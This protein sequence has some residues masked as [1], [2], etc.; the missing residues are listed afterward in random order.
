[1]LGL[2]ILV[3]LRGLQVASTSAKE[4]DICSNSLRSIRYASEGSGWPANSILF[5]H[6]D[7]AY[8]AWQR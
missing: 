1:M 7:R 2:L 4:L 5:F 6:D 3:S 8:C